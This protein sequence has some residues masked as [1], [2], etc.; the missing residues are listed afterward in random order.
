MRGMCDV[1]I[2]IFSQFNFIICVST[3]VV[4]LPKYGVEQTFSSQSVLLI[5]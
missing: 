1:A 3:L 4:L 2:H 5:L